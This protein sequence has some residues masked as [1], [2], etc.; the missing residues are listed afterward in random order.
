MSNY[1]KMASRQLP[2]TFKKLVVTKLST[3]FREAVQAVTV[4]MIAPGPEEMLVKTSYAGINASDINFTAGRYTPGQEPPFDVGLEAIGEVVS[5]GDKIKKHFNVGQA[6]TFMKYGAFAEYILLSKRDAIPVPSVHPDFISL[7]ISGMTA[8][9]A[10]DKMGDL[11]SGEKVLVTAAA[12]G[13]GQFAVQLAKQAG[14]HVIGTCSSQEKVDLLK[15]LGCDRPINY[16]TEELNDVL[17]AEY[18]EG[19]DVVYES[20]G[21][22]IFDV[23]VNRLATKG[24]LIVIGFITGYE[25]KLGFNPV[26]TG[27]LIPKLLTKSASVRGF[28]LF[29]YV[30]DIKTYM[31]RLIQLYQS[32]QIKTAVDMGENSKAGPFRGLTSVYD[33]V[34]HMYK[35]LNRGKLVVQIS[36]D[37]KSHL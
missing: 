21:G 12:G 37:P 26:K 16:K 31:P 20:I 14:C 5:V 18:P 3:N 30:S 29:N 17:K 10:L 11:K 13:T 36:N 9:M 25:S 4:P 35:G 7:L 6:V 32:G 22:N 8:A 1:I 24:R 28:F 27:T 15:S 34:E 19:V 23:C 2:K 33:A